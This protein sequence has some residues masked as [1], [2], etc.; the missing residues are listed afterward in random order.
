MSCHAHFEAFRHLDR[1][2]V[3]CDHEP[4]DY[5]FNGYKCC[6]P[7]GALN[8][9]K[10]DRVHNEY[11]AECAACPDCKAAREATALHTQLNNTIDPDQPYGQHIMLTCLNHNDLRWHTKNIDC[12]GARSIFYATRDKAEC[13]CSAR[14]L[15][16]VK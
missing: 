12:I 5:T 8:R 14:D 11:E 3:Q 1:S 7:C 15:I 13:D 16:V 4:K 10:W 9:D 6:K 2:F